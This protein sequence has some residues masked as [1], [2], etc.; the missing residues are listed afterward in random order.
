MS[1]DNFFK[2][3]HISKND[4]LYRRYIKQTKKLERLFNNETGV[5]EVLDKVKI[6]QL[7]WINKKVHV[8]ILLLIKFLQISREPPT[9][10]IQKIINHRISTKINHFFKSPE[11]NLPL[12]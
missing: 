11:T 5:G 8:V 12:Y 3:V 10:L 6:G 4:C 7:I 9:V 2:V 1:K